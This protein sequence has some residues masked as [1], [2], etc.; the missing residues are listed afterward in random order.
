[1]HCTAAPAVP[2]VR[3]STAATAT[4]RPA[5]ASTV[6]CRWIALLPDDRLGLG[7][8][9]LGEQVH[10]RLVLPGRRVDLPRLL[11]TDRRWCGARRED[12]L[13]HRD[14]Q[15]G[16]ADLDVGVGE[17]AE[18]LHDLGGV[19]VHAADTVCAGAS[20]HLGAEQV[21]LRCLAGAAGAAGGNDDDVAGVDDAGRDGG[22]ER[23]AGDRSGSSREPRCAWRRAGGSRWSPSSGSP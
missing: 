7:P 1:M 2:L 11:G 6:T 18:V 22:C 13:R 20:H 14:E 17:G 8:L 3:L 12:A 10:E 23:E 4:S 16:E 9:P 21:G 15:R 5:A 19:P